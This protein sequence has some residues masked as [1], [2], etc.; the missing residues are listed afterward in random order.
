MADNEAAGADLWLPVIGKSLAYLCLAK[1]TEHEPE[2][3]KGLLDK[4]T[5]LRGLGLPFKDAAE[6]AGSSADSVS[7]MLR[8]RKK[9]KDGKAKKSRR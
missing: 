3:Y 6:A 7:A 5:F 9:T 8:Q 1:A 4:V 2:K